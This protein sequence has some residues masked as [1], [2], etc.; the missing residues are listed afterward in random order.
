MSVDECIEVF[1]ALSSKVFSPKSG[2]P[3][4]WRGQINARFDSRNMEGVVKSIL[5]KLGLS[6]DA[7]LQDSSNR[8]CK[9]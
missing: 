5:T 8:K 3:I 2:F 9:V 4:N 7:L 1:M 6:E